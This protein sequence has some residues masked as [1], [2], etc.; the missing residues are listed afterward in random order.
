MG[1]IIDMLN[2]VAVIA[3][4]SGAV[5]EFQFR[6]GNIRSAADSAFV[7]IVLLYRGFIRSGFGL[8]CDYLRALL[9]PFSA[10]GIG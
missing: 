8:E 10:P 6:I 9:F 2:A 1:V 4:A 5:A 3:I 7:V